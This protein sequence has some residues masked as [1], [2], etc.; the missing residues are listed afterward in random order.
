MGYWTTELDGPVATLTF[1]R[2]P[3]NQLRFADL[4]ELERLLSAIGSNSDV[5][6]VV[7][8]SSC[9]GYFL[10]HAD[11]EEIERLRRGEPGDETGDTLARWMSTTACIESLPQPIV[12]AIDGQAWGGGCESALACTFRI[13]TPATH[14]SQMEILRG[15]MPGA[16]A[17]QRLP[18]IIGSSRAAHMLMTG[19]KVEA[20]EALRIGLLDAVITEPDFGH[21]V[22]RWVSEIAHQPRASL[23]GIKKAMYDGLRLPVDDAYRNEQRLFNEVLER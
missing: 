1:D 15:A 9:P 4:R 20:D 6:V 10:G 5:S 18:R 16:G 23:V 22:R 8:Q 3:D 2:R 11:L 13:G 14:F 19:R 21:G 12:A 17:T 7:L